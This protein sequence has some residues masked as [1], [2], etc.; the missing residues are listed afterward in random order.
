[1]KVGFICSY[2]ICQFW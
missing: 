1:M 2:K